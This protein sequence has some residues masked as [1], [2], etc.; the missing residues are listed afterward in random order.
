MFRKKISYSYKSDEELM[1]LICIGDT[2]AFDEIH[3]RYRRKLMGYFMRML[4]FEKQVSEDAVQDIFLKIASFPEKFD[5][6]RPFKTWIFSVASNYCKNVFRHEAVKKQYESSL[7]DV[8]SSDHTDIY[9]DG[10][11]DTKYFNESLHAVLNELPPERKEAFIL[12]YQEEKSITEIAEIQECPE[13]SVKSRIH[14]TI[15]L[16]EQKLQQ[17]HHLIK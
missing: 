13:G 12:R 17:Y 11:I 14:Y 2:K 15:K 3:Y 7:S 16:L 10:K 8:N 6:S 4:R 9:L 5:G 1:A